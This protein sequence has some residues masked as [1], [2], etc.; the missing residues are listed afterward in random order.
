MGH[1]GVLRAPSLP[2]KQGLGDEV[3]EKFHLRCSQGKNRHQQAARSCHSQDRVK[4][5]NKHLPW[6][7]RGCPS[8]PRA[9][10]PIDFILGK[11][12]RKLEQGWFVLVWIT[13]GKMCISGQE[14]I[15][16][17]PCSRGQG[18]SRHPEEKHETGVLEQEDGKNET[19]AT[20]SLDGEGKNPDIARLYHGAADTKPEGHVHPGASASL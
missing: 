14:V 12:P 1:F 18:R 20:A 8:F 11:L 13:K 7:S 3:M 16:Q 4:A 5:T 19:N 2:A 10:I 17:N 6:F 15:H 9:L